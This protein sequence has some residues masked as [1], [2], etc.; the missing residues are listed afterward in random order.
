VKCSPEI[1]QLKVSH[2]EMSTITRDS[3]L[4]HD[5]QLSFV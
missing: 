2:N 4:S 3:Y 5:S 1:D